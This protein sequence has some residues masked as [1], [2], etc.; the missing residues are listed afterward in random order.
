MSFSEQG[1]LFQLKINVIISKKYNFTLAYESDISLMAKVSLHQLLER[2]NNSELI[3]VIVNTE[4]SEFVKLSDEF[5]S[6]NVHHRKGIQTPI[7]ESV[8]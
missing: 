8:D 1:P 4:E 7:K 5:N 3:R 2:G 6:C